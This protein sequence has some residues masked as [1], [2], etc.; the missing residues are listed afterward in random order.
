MK[1][2]IGNDHVALE[3]KQQISAYLE[4]LGHEVID[5]GTHTTER[6]DY[7]VYGEQVANAV[8]SGQA[9]R[10][11]LICG[12]GVGMSMAANKIRG[13]RACCCSDYFTAKFTRLHNDANVLCFGARVISKGLACEL[14]KV[15]LESEF[16]GGRHAPRV[17]HLMDMEKEW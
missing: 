5:F 14:V 9:E 8:V 13:I 6:C 3:M 17:Q 1:I 16:E 7:P 4:E 10:G 15:F 11:I 2:A 12:T